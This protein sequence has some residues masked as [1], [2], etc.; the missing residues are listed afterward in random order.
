MD[1]LDSVQILKNKIKKSIRPPKVQTLHF[2]IRKYPRAGENYITN[3]LPLVNWPDQDFW[4]REKK[5]PTSYIF[6]YKQPKQKN[7]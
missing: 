5:K 3:S 7:I 6:I 4:E 2:S 1:I